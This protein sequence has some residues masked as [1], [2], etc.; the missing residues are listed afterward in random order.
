MSD[1]AESGAGDDTEEEADGSVLAEATVD[2]LVELYLTSEDDWDRHKKY[3]EA[4]ARRPAEDLER[5]ARRQLASDDG[6]RRECGAELLSLC[7]RSEDDRTRHLPMFLS[8]L[9]D[10]NTSV[11]EAALR[12]IQRAQLDWVDRE[13]TAR[14]KSDKDGRYSAAWEDALLPSRIDLA[15]IAF[16]VSHPD[17]YV[18]HCL[19]Q[20]LEFCGETDATAILLGLTWDEDEDV[21]AHAGL[22]LGRRWVGGPIGPSIERLWQLVEEAS[23]YVRACAITAL[24]KLGREDAEPL[25]ESFLRENLAEKRSQMCYWPLELLLWNRPGLISAELTM[26]LEERK[27]NRRRP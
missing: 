25:V 1:E 12:S 9:R 19:S 13:W 8:L 27:R 20:C 26:M 15:D 23:P 24:V 14:V 2:E 6:A 10:D 17:S 22:A 3:R 7:G 18:R 5:A 11:I 16:V 4:L 21:R